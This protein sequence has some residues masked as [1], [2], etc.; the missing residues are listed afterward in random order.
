MLA[1]LIYGAAFVDSK[2]IADILAPRW[3]QTIRAENHDM[4][5]ETAKLVAHERLQGV[6][7]WIVAAL[8]GAAAIFRIS[9]AVGDDDTMKKSAIFIAVLLILVGTIG[10]G[11]TIVEEN[12]GK[13]IGAI[14]SNS[15]NIF[16]LFVGLVTASIPAV[17]IEVVSIKIDKVYGGIIAK[18]N[19]S[20]YE[21]LSTKVEEELSNEAPA[22][23][24]TSFLSMTQP[25][26]TGTI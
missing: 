23:K 17:L 20:F 12:K 26:K 9:P 14:F 13:S 11:F 25:S 7:F 19:K 5:A 24:R 3:V 22:K 10:A 1:V 21:R 2:A 4:S 18:I 16:M 15:Y 6:A 8:A